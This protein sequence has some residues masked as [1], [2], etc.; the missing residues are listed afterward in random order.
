[1]FPWESAVTGNEVCPG[2]IYSDYEQHITADIGFAAKQYWMGSRD[3]NWLKE[4][5]ADLISA[6]AEFWASRVVFNESKNAYVIY[7]VM[8]PDEDRGVVNN[9]VYTNTI[10]KLNLEFATK[11]I[12]GAPKEWV[13]IAT[14]MYIPF[15]NE[16]QYHPEYD[17]Y[18][19]DIM[20]KQAD[21][22]LL[23]F[24]LM[25]NMSSQVRKNDLGI[26]EPRTNP[27]GPAMTKSMFAINWLDVGELDKAE[28]SFTKSLGN[29]QEPFKVWTET[30]GGGAV[31]FIT[32]AGGFL[33]SV[34][35]GY[36]GFKL[37]EDHLE[38]MPRLLPNTTSMKITGLDYL[39]NSIDVTIGTT[40]S[41]V[42]V[43]SRASSS[44]TIEAVIEST[45]K[46]STLDIGKVV[47]FSNELVFIRV[48]EQLDCPTCTG[49]DLDTS[50]AH[51]Q[52]ILF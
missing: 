15:D 24:P 19:L 4:T 41:N 2:Q 36:G 23:G 7:N 52:D 51:D 48:L 31:N 50:T 28:R 1:M 40:S 47:S 6:T 46:K 35:F 16:K 44:P 38:F 26:Y 20:V 13:T 45:Q 18:S 17:G 10:A 22:I 8:P 12:K 42:T 29:I 5:G 32:G 37:R 3:T 21:V 49:E 34:L 30:P 33:Q 11:M 25:F 14:K 9:S 39:G 43:T 27:D